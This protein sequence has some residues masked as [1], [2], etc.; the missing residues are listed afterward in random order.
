[1]ARARAGTKKKR[2]TSLASPG[3]PAVVKRKRKRKKSSSGKAS[4]EKASTSR[5]P[6]ASPMGSAGGGVTGKPARATRTT[7]AKSSQDKASDR[8]PDRKK[9]KI[10]E[11]RKLA[12][13]G[14]SGKRRLSRSAAA[15]RARR[16]R[17]EER[18]V[19][20]QLAAE[21]IERREA[22]AERAKERK[23]GL[24]PN[25]RRLAIGWLSQIRNVVA[26][27]FHCSLEL[28]SAE[29]GSRTPWIIVGRYEPQEPIGY[30]ELA[31]ALVNV[32]NDLG[33]E[34]D[35]NPQRLSQIRIVYSDPRAHRGEGDSIVSKIGAWEYIIA[36]LVSEIVGSGPD[37][38]DSLAV[39]YQETS[40]PKFYIYFSSTIVNYVTASAWQR[41]G[42]R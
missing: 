38:E 37:D 6:P 40:V 36:D 21:R 8:K 9:S 13:S 19:R 12:K 42:M 22:A 25:E 24:P 18:G 20:D 5:T 29:A 11:K 28:T 10:K 1:M 31:Q 17:R 33:I 3:S 15:V 23:L 41:V 34:T 4:S 27:V 14:A 30:R 2:K 7:R 16:R 32:A 26:E 39:R 35:I